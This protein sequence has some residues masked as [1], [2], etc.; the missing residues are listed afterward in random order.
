MTFVLGAVLPAVLSPPPSSSFLFP[1]EQASALCHSYFFLPGRERGT[2]LRTDGRTE[3][4]APP[5]RRSIDRS[6]SGKE[7]GGGCWSTGGQTEERRSNLAMAIAGRR[8]RRNIR[9]PG[10]HP[11]R[12]VGGRGTVSQSVGPQNARTMAQTISSCCCECIAIHPKF[13]PRTSLL[14]C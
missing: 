7:G 10:F 5:R 12:E 3:C 11:K 8:R 2:A 1:S 4:G 9:F 13:A 6:W 14:H